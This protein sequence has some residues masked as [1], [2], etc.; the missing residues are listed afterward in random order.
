M[1]RR[2]ASHADIFSRNIILVFAGS[3]LVS[4]FNLVAQLY[5]AHRLSPQDFATFNS[6]IAIFIIFSSPLNTLQTAI[7]KYSAEFLAHNQLNKIKAL[8]SGFMQIAGLFAI[9]VF[10]LFYLFSSTIAAKFSISCLPCIY[11]LGIMVALSALV[12]VLT[13]VMQGL[14]LFLWFSAVAVS[15]GVARLALTVL[16]IN[17]GLNITGAM[18]AVLASVIITVFL[19]GFPIAKYFTFKLDKAQINFREIFFYIFPI[20]LSTICFMGLV[21]MDMI[22]VKV[23]FLPFD[24]GIYALSQM[25]GKIFLFLPMAISIVMFPRTSGLKAR[26]QDTGA[27][28]KRSLLYGAMLCVLAGLFYNLFPSLVLKVLT[29]KAFPES[30]LLGRLFSISMTFF[31]LGYIFI[32]YFLSVKDLRFIRP[33]SLFTVLQ[34]LAIIILHPTLVAVQLIL[35]AN[36]ILLFLINLTLFL[37]RRRL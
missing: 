25:V 20:A 23:F 24:S 36:A 10:L 21:N 7:T 35:C 27:T 2:L 13:G 16:F 28:F 3:S 9:G 30:V 4:I 1:I 22:L 26:N 12:P 33:L 18:D 19:S 34:F 31:T 15:A 11:I 32:A 29:G 8:F 37:R 14:E 5:T 6:L 17:A